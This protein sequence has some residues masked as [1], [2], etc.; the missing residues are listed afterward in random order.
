MSRRFSVE[1]MR[2]WRRT[3]SRISGESERHWPCERLPGVGSGRSRP[4]RD[5]DVAQLTLIR[6]RPPIAGRVRY[7]LRS[8]WLRSWGER[9]AGPNASPCLPR[10]SGSSLC[11][12][13]VARTELATS[14]S[15]HIGQIMLTPSV[16][17]MICS[18][19]APQTDSSCLNSTGR[20]WGCD[21]GL[22]PARAA[23]VAAAKHREVLYRLLDTFDKEIALR[24]CF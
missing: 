19:L 6:H 16:V 24:S 11:N 4:P 12:C 2:P 1:L 15:P 10:S 13:S 17:D 9:P 21:L 18:G 22:A 5:D 8:S 23:S 7:P 14:Y 20:F 3:G